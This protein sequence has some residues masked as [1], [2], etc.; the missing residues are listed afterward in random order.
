MPKLCFLTKLSNIHENGFNHAV[1]NYCFLVG[2]F[3]TITN[4]LVS[5][6]IDSL[7]WG[8]NNQYFYTIIM[9]KMSLII[10]GPWMSLWRKDHLFSWAVFRHELRKGAGRKKF[11]LG[12]ILLSS[13]RWVSV[14]S[15]W[16]HKP[17]FCIIYWCA[18]TFFSRLD[19]VSCKKLFSLFIFHCSG[20]LISSGSSRVLFSTF[21]KITQ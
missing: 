4:G 16:F 20:W 10:T 7:L 15:V 17:F 9:R 3:G 12:F 18:S 19:L 2:F 13:R 21:Y 6:V 14:E 11:L 5:L 1:L 8:C